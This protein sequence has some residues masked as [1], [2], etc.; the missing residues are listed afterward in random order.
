[1][2]SV[3]AVRCALCKRTV[4]W[5]PQMSELCGHATPASAPECSGVCVNSHRTRRPW[6]PLTSCVCGSASSGRF[7]NVDSRGVASPVRLPWLHKGFGVPRV[8]EWLHGSFG[9]LPTR[10]P[11]HRAAHRFWPFTGLGVW[12]VCEQRCSEHGQ[13]SFV[14]ACSCGCGLCRGFRIKALHCC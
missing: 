8:G 1:M 9:E 7:T 2:C 13:P 12:S 11:P 5:F 6:Q 14:C 4:Q 10:T 3:A